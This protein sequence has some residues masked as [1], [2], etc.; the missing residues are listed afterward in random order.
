MTPYAINSPEALARLITLFMLADGEISDNELDTLEKLDVFTL[1]DLDR[2]GFTQVFKTYFDDISGEM[3]NDGAVHLVDSA[4]FDLLLKD[5]TDH[6]KR[7]LLCI[8]ALDLTK[9]DHDI[10]EVEMTLL[11]QMMSRW[12]V[13]LDEVEASLKAI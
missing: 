4:R 1:I 12:Q 9:S 5:V 7:L 2:K 13:S 6:N 11:R 10:N 3:E 8:V